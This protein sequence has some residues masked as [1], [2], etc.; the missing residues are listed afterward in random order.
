VV[1]IKGKPVFAAS[2]AA[3]AACTPSEPAAAPPSTD[4]APLKTEAAGTDAPRAPVLVATNRGRKTLS[5]AAITLGRFVVEQGCLRFTTSERSYL[6]V[7][8]G[9]ATG[10]GPAVSS[11]GF[12]YSGRQIV[13]GKDY[14]I[15]GGPSGL[16]PGVF[17]LAPEVERA[18]PGPYFQVGPVLRG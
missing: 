13:L 9:G 6:A 11:A 16:E 17:E 14:Q 5:P 18:C 12:T 1:S 2:A 4:T 7:F 10:G 3:L 15:G 8:G